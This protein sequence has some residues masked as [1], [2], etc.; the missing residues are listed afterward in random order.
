[1]RVDKA[2]MAQ[3]LPTPGS[4]IGASEPPVTI[5]SA[6]PHRMRFM[7]SIMAWFDEAQADTVQ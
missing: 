7:A 5:R 4:L 6:L 2:C 1:M 3:K